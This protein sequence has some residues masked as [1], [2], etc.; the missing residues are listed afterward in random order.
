MEINSNSQY[1]YTK[2]TTIKQS[3]EKKLEGFADY[4][5][6]PIMSQNKG[7]AYYEEPT[8]KSEDQF[9]YFKG[10]ASQELLYKK[11]LAWAKDNNPNQYEWMTHM[12]S[13][14]N[15]N[16]YDDAP[17]FE[18]FVQKWM[19]KGETE[20][21]A[22][23]RASGYALAGLLDYGKQKAQSFVEMLP[24]EDTKQHGMWLIDNPP[25]KEAI[26]NTLDNLDTRD[27][28]SFIG[29][30]FLGWEDD[31]NSSFEDLLK[32]YGVKLE[33]LRNKN[34]ESKDD[35][36]TFTGD[37]NLKNDNSQES[38]EYN[39]FIFDTLLDYFKDSIEKVNQYEKKHNEDFSTQKNSLNTFIDNF[40]IT[41]DE[42]NKE[43]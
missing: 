40:K 16:K 8:A 39:N 36:Y 43:K 25:L 27:I 4:I 26:L 13:A 14:T 6:K 3:T 22:I 34:P 5:D 15:G 17:E 20:Q 37:I 9:V 21:E 30:I 2:T 23:D 24:V 28:N 32:Q 35:K 42:Y 10:S 11:N 38:I 33:D 19:D 18:A 29:N 31:S 12:R 41:I 7:S 1:T